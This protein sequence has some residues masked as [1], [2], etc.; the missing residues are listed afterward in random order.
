VAIDSRSDLKTPASLDEQV[1]ATTILGACTHRY[2]TEFK[3][4]HRER[5]LVCSEC[6][7]EFD[8]S[9]LYFDMP[10]TEPEMSPSDYLLRFVPHTAQDEL[11]A[12]LV[13]RRVEGA[14]W[15]AM[16]RTGPGGFVQT[17]SRNGVQFASHPRSVKAAAICEAAAQLARSGQLK[18]DL[19]DDPA[20]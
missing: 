2:W 19:R 12:A 5:V 20:P 16:M 6:A 8:F 3:D 4:K 7:R 10:R 9:G 15:T 18:L 1:V 11:L 17:F 14:G 13:V